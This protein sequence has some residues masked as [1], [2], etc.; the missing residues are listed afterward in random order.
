MMESSPPPLVSPQKLP[1]QHPLDS[2]RR[3]W[4]SSSKL[5]RSSFDYSEAVS[6]AEEFLTLLMNRGKC[7][8][9]FNPTATIECT[10]MEDFDLSNQ[11]LSEFIDYLINYFKLSWEEQRSLILE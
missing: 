11:E 6:L 2:F 8:D 3:Q 10:C 4:K 9:L 1:S 5:E 7:R